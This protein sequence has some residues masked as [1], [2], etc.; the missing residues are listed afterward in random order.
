MGCSKF[1]AELQENANQEENPPRQKK[2]LTH[3]L[4]P[5]ALKHPKKEPEKEG[6]PHLFLSASPPGDEGHSGGLVKI[7]QK[8]IP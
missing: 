8:L 6:S 3:N 4:V 7:L 1:W 2:F 5:W